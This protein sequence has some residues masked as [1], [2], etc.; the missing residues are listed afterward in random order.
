MCPSFVLVD[1]GLTDAS[2]GR[3]SSGPSFI[4]LYLILV[5]VA[6]ARIEVLSGLDRSCLPIVAHA[7]I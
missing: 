1:F 4:Y 2:Q 7:I 5:Y 3:W 6:G